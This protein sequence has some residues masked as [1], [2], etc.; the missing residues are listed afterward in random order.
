MDRK[1]QVLALIGW[2]AASFVAAGVGARFLPGEWYAALVKPAWTPPD[3]VFGP[4]WTVLYASMAVAAWRVWRAWRRAAAHGARGALTAYLVQLALNALWSY[5]FFGLHRPALA[6][7]E[8]VALWLAIAIT[9]VLFWRIDR[10]AGA[11]LVPYLA[12]VT[13]A[14]SLNLALWRLNPA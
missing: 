3:W 6:F 2:L 12:W 10:L 1:K 14:G 8:L 5:L 11:L 7:L 9:L 4:V 13:L